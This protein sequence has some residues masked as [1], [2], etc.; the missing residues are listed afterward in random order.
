[1]KTNKKKVFHPRAGP[2]HG[3]VAF[4]LMINPALTRLHWPANNEK[5][6]WT[7]SRCRSCFICNNGCKVFSIFFS[8]GNTSTTLP[9]VAVSQIML[10]TPNST[11][12]TTTTVT[13]ITTTST[14]D[15]S[16]SSDDSQVL[17]ILIAFFGTL[18]L[19]AAFV[20]IT[21]LII[22]WSKTRK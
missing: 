13:T 6:S 11:T 10:S 15:T 20:S 3:T 17:I 22:K 16:S 4:C 8:D 2:L 19:V 7:L 5:I 18:I 1:M 14:Q 12:T 21:R 9:S